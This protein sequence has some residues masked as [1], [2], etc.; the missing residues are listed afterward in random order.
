MKRLHSTVNETPMVHLFNS[1]RLEG[2]VTRVVDVGRPITPQGV[3]KAGFTDSIT[4]MIQAHPGD[5]LSIAT[6]LI[7]TNDGFS[8][9]DGAR[10]PKQGTSVFLTNA[11]DAGREVKTEKAPDLVEACSLLGPVT[12]PGV[13]PSPNN[14]PPI[15]PPYPIRLHAGIQ[16]IGDLSVCTAVRGKPFD[17]AVSESL[18]TGRDHGVEGYRTRVTAAALSSLVRFAVAD[19][20]RTATVV[21]FGATAA[22]TQQ[23]HSAQSHGSPLA[24]AQAGQHSSPQQATSLVIA[25]TSSSV[26]SQHGQSPTWPQS[27]AGMRNSRR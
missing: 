6:M 5:R 12:L 21:T 9:L 16:G 23:G 3:V 8:S 11:C 13:H 2:D 25:F 18:P 20:P 15:V 10:L 14:Y 19:R 4:F 26:G 7:C 17:L 1:L 22:D 24:Q 27:G